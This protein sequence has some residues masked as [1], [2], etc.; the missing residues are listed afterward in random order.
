MISEVLSRVETLI[1]V[2]RDVCYEWEEETAKYFNVPIRQI[3]ATTQP[4]RKINSQVKNAKNFIKKLFPIIIRLRR[5]IIYPA[6]KQDLRD[7]V[8]I[9]FVMFPG[10]MSICVGNNCIPIFLDVWSDQEIQ[11]IIRRTRKLKI[12]YV[13][14]RDVYNRIKSISRYNNVYYMPLSI[15]DKYYSPNFEAYRDKKIDVIQI[16]RINPM[17][18]EYMLKYVSEH[19]TIDYVYSDNGTNSRNK[20][21]STLR[22]KLEQITDR[23]EFMKTLASAKVSLLGCS[24][25]DNARENTFGI[26]FPTPRFYESAILGCVLIGRYPENQEFTELNMKKYCP[27][28]TSYESFVEALEKALAITP[29]ELYAQ[30]H[31]FIINSLTSKRAEQIKHDLEEIISNA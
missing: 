18:H 19:E 2:F 1:H 12:F 11:E 13:T 17:L 28:I 15:A 31:D 16:G 30:N 3:I 5:E 22:G 14:S 23:R 29:E 26:C 20:Y 9:C 25:I 8:A 24:G 7:K 10:E 6:L 21:I 27:N 4:S